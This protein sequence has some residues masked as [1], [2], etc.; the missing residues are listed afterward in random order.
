MEAF[1]LAV[2][3]FKEK[4]DQ[5]ERASSSKLSAVIQLPDQR[6]KVISALAKRDP[7]APAN[8]PSKCFRTMRAM[9]LTNPTINPGE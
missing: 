9:S 2:Q 3:N 1:D 6:F 5:I 8:S 4:G 7:R